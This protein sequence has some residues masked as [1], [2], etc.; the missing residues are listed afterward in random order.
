VDVEYE[1]LDG[2]AETRRKVGES[3]PQ[4]ENVRV[5]LVDRP[6]DESWQARVDVR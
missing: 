6:S 2:W 4:D 1:R 5:H 3:R